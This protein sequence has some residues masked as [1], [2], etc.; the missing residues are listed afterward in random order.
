MI[1][2]LL[3]YES[4]INSSKVYYAD[5]D[6]L[7]Q[8]AKWGR[9]TRHVGNA[10]KLLLTRVDKEP[11][12]QLWISDEDSPADRKFDACMAG[13]LSWQARMECMKFLPKKRGRVERVR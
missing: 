12:K 2:A 5:T 3:A 9:L 7:G 13:V 10:G 6:E 1:K 4:A 11:G 8:P